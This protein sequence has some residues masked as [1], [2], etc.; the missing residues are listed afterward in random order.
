MQT[1]TSSLRT[2][3]IMPRNLN[4]IVRSW[5]R[6]LVPFA[7]H[8]R[9]FC[10]VRHLTYILLQ[11]SNLFL[12][13]CTKYDLPIWIA[14]CKHTTRQIRVHTTNAGNPIAVPCSM[15]MHGKPVWGCMSCPVLSCPVLSCPVLSCPVLSCP[16][17]SCPALH[18]LPFPAPSRPVP[19]RPVLSCSVLSCPVLLTIK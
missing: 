2:L 15:F 10:P 4:D 14:K 17:L 13:M 19:S 5:I 9:L 3:A 7:S 12:L 6:L 8:I 16:A 1:E 18:A 11:G